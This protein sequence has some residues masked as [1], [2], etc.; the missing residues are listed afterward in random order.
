MAGIIPSSLGELTNLRILY[1]VSVKVI[2][3]AVVVMIAVV[4]LAVV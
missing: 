2:V 1:M 3:A 4:V